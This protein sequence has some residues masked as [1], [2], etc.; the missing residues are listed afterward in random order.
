M[1]LRSAAYLPTLYALLALHDTRHRSNT[2]AGTFHQGSSSFR[3]SQNKY[4][5]GRSATGDTAE[6]LKTTAV[7]IDAD[8]RVARAEE[9]INQSCGIL[10]SQL[11]GQWMVQL[12]RW[13]NTGIDEMGNGTHPFDFSTPLWVAQNLLS[14]V[15]GTGTVL[16]RHVWSICGKQGWKHRGPPPLPCGVG[17]FL[18]LGDKRVTLS[19]L[20][21]GR[22]GG[23]NTV[24]SPLVNGSSRVAASDPARLHELSTQL[25]TLRMAVRN[26]VSALLGEG[27]AAKQHGSGE[28]STE[29]RLDVVLGYPVSLS[30]ILACPLLGQTCSSPTASSQ[31]SPSSLLFPRDQPR[32]TPMQTSE[33]IV[34]GSPGRDGALPLASALG[35]GNMSAKRP[36]GFQTR[37]SLDDVRERVRPAAQLT[38]VALSLLWCAGLFGEADCL[39]VFAFFLRYLEAEAQAQAARERGTAA[40]HVWSAGNHGEMSALMGDAPPAASTGNDDRQL[41]G[42][43]E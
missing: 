15:T 40:W 6:G 11:V 43:R 34:N 12:G 8:S 20:S 29:N 18:R 42:V 19:V 16:E 24:L 25:F 22:E 10:H 31:R 23:T 14:E 41:C 4:S 5:G 1:G 13:D 32:P 30:Y 33:T 21:A 38:F 2:V 7:S 9:M 36:A 28:W 26:A 37:A 27:P 17:S 35:K 3:V 39:R